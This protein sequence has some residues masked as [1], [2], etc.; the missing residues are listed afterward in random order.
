MRRKRKILQAV[1]L[2]GLCLKCF[3][4]GLKRYGHVCYIVVILSSI[5]FSSKTNWRELVRIFPK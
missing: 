3:N 1:K 2:A 5:S 4:V